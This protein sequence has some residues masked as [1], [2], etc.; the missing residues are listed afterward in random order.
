M[1]D[2]SLM[3]REVSL[4]NFRCFPSLSLQFSSPIVLIEGDNG[5]GKTSVLEALH[6]A[7][8]LRSFRALSPAQMICFNEPAFS[9]SL[10]GI[11]RNEVWNLIVGASKEQRM[12]KLNGASLSTHKQIFDYYRVITINEHDLDLIAGGPQ[13]RRSFLD[14]TLFLLDT[15]YGILLKQYAKI[16]KQRAALLAHYSF[17]HDAYA[18]WTEKFFNVSAEIQ[19]KRKALL[20]EL[21]KKVQGLLKIYCPGSSFILLCEYVEKKYDDALLQRERIVK[22]VLFGAHLDDVSIIYS[23]VSARTYASRGQ[24]KMLVI[25]FKLAVMQLL[26]KPTIL[27]LDD[28]M[29]D[30]D[31]KKTEQL[32]EALIATQSQIIATSP[33]KQSILSHILKKYDTQIIALHDS[34]L[35]QSGSL[36]SLHGNESSLI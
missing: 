9:I 4:K 28:F 22:K 19:V 2:A 10:K 12:V 8:Y 11:T 1:N 16:V 20:R 27:L 14:G 33:M 30:F 13:M 17:D 6:Y 18:L 31:Q 34:N 25:L 35:P 36:Y 5:T 24:Q 26:Q 21:E 32:L 29:T 23:D 3:I 7:C 15:E